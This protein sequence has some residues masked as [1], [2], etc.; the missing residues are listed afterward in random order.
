MTDQRSHVPVDV[1]KRKKAF[2]SLCALYT[3]YV[4][5]DGTLTDLRS[6]LEED[7]IMATSDRFHAEGKDLGRSAEKHVKWATIREVRSWGYCSF[8]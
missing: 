4:I 1:V 5:K 2:S 6:V 3:C 7:Q 8:C